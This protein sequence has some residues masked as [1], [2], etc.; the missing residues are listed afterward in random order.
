[1]S[2]LASKFVKPD[3]IE[4]FKET[5]QPF[6]N[7]D[8]SL[9][10]QD[11]NDNLVIGFTTCQKLKK[12]LQED[13]DERTSDKFLS[14]AQSFYETTYDYCRKW[15]PL[16]FPFFK[17]CQFVNFDERLEHGIEEV[18]QIITMM[19]HLHG[20]F[21]VDVSLVDQLEEEFILYQ[22]MS[23]NEIP[24]RTQDEAPVYEKETTV[25]H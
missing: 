10:N 9:A 14:A 3:V 23:N 15:L 21:Q 18:M 1:M 16:N 2:Q 6:S 7:L 13:T 17:H 8:I 20:K 11:S 4:A 25:Y 5:G 19:P 24:Q 22:G 12:L